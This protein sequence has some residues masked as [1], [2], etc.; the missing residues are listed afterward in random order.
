MADILRFVVVGTVAVAIR[1]PSTA[2]ETQI[3]T[4]SGPGTVFLG[5][6]SGVTAALGAP[7]PPGSRLE[8][9]NQGLPI[10]AVNSAGGQPANIVV[11]AG[12]GAV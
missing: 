3:I 7:F 1:N 11:E 10:F 12:V 9:F 2:K 4:N 8:T 5:Q 6:T